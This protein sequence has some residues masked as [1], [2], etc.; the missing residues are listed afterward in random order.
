MRHVA[1]GLNDIFLTGY[2]GEILHI[3]EGS[4]LRLPMRG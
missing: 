3:V 2:V 4:S 1:E